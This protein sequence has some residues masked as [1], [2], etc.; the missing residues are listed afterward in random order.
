MSICSIIFF[1]LQGHYCFTELIAIIYGKHRFSMNNKRQNPNRTLWAAPLLPISPTVTQWRSPL[2]HSLLRF[3]NCRLLI[4]WCGFAVSAT[5][6]L[7][8][9][10]PSATKTDAFCLPLIEKENR[11]SR[12]GFVIRQTKSLAQTVS[13]SGRSGSPPVFPYSDTQT[14]THLFIFTHLLIQTHYLCM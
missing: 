2:N 1:F 10:R 4:Y 8:R 6:W 3:V 7:N 14:Q 5:P 11:L 13:S 9:L 12:R